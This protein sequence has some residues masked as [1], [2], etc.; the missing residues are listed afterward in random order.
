MANPAAGIIETICLGL[1]IAIL[2][3]NFRVYNNTGDNPLEK[4]DKDINNTQIALNLFI[5]EDQ[6]SKP[7]NKIFQEYGKYCQCDEKIL[8]NICSEEQII[9]GCFDVSKKSDKIL[10][11]HLGDDIC[12]DV[13][14]LLQ[15]KD[16]KF[17]KV[18]DLGFDMVHKMALGLLVIVI[19]VLCVIGLGLL[20]VICTACCGEGAL[21]ILVPFLPCIICVAAFSGIVNLVLFIILMVNYYKGRTTGDF[22]D[23]YNKCADDGQKQLLK[24]TFEELDSLDSNMTAFVV[25]N[26][27]GMFFNIISSCLNIANKEDDNN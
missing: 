23:Y 1:F 13:N 6:D 24:T 15:K 9:S 2:V 16:N 7:E 3:F 5:N 17:S 19:A 10:L 21:A 27:I 20:T 25:L 8:N 4:F 11:R 18:F 26:F 22:L 14:F 12:Q